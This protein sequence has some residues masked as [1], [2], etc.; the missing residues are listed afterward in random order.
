MN[1]LLIGCGNLG[2]ALL[3]SWVASLRYQHVVVVEPS[4]NAQAEFQTQANIT[5]V[6]DPQQIPDT[7]VPDAIVIAVKPQQLGSV[8]THYQRFVAHSLF[9]SVVTAATVERLKQGLGN[10]ATCI[11]IMPNVALQVGAST[12]L[13]FASTQSKEA[14]KQMTEKIFSPTG[15]VFWLEEESWLETLTPITGSGPAYF[16]LL[17]QLLINDAVARGI[18]EHTAS[19]SVRQTLLGS[20][21]LAQ[22]NADLLALKKSVTSKG[23]VTEAALKVLEPVLPNLIHEAIGNALNRQEE[24]AL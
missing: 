7:F 21:L 14:D 22:K 10:Q 23:G 1:L 11:R 6:P 8:L 24:L 13:A 19:E 12:N 18:D 20:A 16:F 2:K 4:L 9:I 15:R 5:F 17:A 3:S